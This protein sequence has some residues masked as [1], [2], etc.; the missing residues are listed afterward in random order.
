MKKLLLLSCFSLFAFWG[1]ANNANYSSFEENDSEALTNITFCLD[2]TSCPVGPAA[3]ALVADFNNFSNGT[4]FLGGTATPNVYCKTVALNAGNYVFQFFTAN[5]QFE[6]LAAE[7]CAVVYNGPTYAAPNHFRPITVVEG[8]PQTV[9]YGWNTCNPA[10]AEVTTT[11]ITFCVDLSCFPGADAVAV[12]GTFN[13][14]SPGVNFLSNNGSGT[15]CGTVAVPAGPHEFKFFFAQ[16]QW[17]D[18]T[19]GDPCVV[20]NN[21]AITVVEGVPQTVTY[22]WESCTADC[23]G[24]AGANVTFCVDVSCLPGINSVNIFGAF[25]GWNG[26]A[27]P[28]S[29]PENDG[30]WCTTIFMTPGAQEYKFLANGLEESFTPGASCTVSCCGDMYTNRVINVTDGGNETVT[31]GWESCNATCFT[32]S[33]PTEAAPSPEFCKNVISMFSNVYPNVPVN[34][35]LTGWSPG[36]TLTDMQIAGNDTKLYQNVSY[37]GIE[38]VGPNLIDASAMTHFNIDVWTPNM[39]TFRVKLVDFGAD[40]QY[41]PWF[42]DSEFELVFNPVPETW[43]T[44]KIPLADFTGLVSVEHIAQLILSGIPAG[45]GIVYVDNVY[46]SN[47]D[48][49]ISLATVQSNLPLWCQGVKKL[50]VKVIN[51]ADLAQPVTFEWSDGLGSSDEVTVFANGTYSVEV[52]DGNGCT[53][54]ASFLVN[55][56]LSTLLSAYTILVEKDMDMDATLVVDGGV[57]VLDADEVSIHHNSDIATFLRSGAVNIDG[58]S[59]VN[60][61][62]NSDCPVVL[63]DFVSN[64]YNNFNDVTVTSNMTLSGANYGNVFVYPGATLYVDN[65]EMYMKSLTVYKDGTLSFNQPTNLMIRRKM[66]IMSSDVN[67][68]GPSVV[69][70]VSDKVSIG[71]GSVIEA[72]IYAPEGMDVG[73][74][75]A[76]LTTYMN[77]LFICDDLNSGDNVVWG[78]N[79]TCGELPEGGIIPFT[80][81][82]SPEIMEDVY[83]NNDVLSLFP[84]PVND[85]LNV[86]LSLDDETSVL[87]EIVNVNGSLI[88]AQTYLFEGASLQLDLGKMNMPVGLYVLNVKTEGGILS[89]RFVKG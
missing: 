69:I 66:N 75:G 87:V 39:T 17:E 36:A 62:I 14:W 71:Q 4:D 50:M 25:N 42:D 57:G 26:G 7:P 65:A 55:E 27:N 16:Q 70:Y 46:F 9:T 86:D 23:S 32:L 1:N 74:S 6:N 83:Q 60:N 59:M 78:W 52:T 35:W 21:R 31:Y 88:Y 68:G 81:P 28:L 53:A 51:I 11:N 22:G 29:D 40:G 5:G 49:V 12:A 33:V 45:S 48:P 73:D 24:P 89:R 72:D 47:D 10:C 13:G 3:A 58:T 34:T 77:G 76:Y 63:P 37:L 79:P 82:Y 61:Y 64:P 84:N 30:T 15:Y 2:L 43:T 20:N 19:P 85:L 67:V 80:S 44:Y 8:I 41:N 38:T 18:L 56:D 54:T